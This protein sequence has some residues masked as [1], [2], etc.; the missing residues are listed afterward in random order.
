[1]TTTA[2]VVGESL[3]DVVV[4]AHGRQEHPGGSPMN[5]AIGLARL[6]GQVH[7]HT[8]FGRDARG[9]AIEIHLAESGVI[10]TAESTTDAATSSATATIGSTGAATYEFGLTSQLEPLRDLPVVDVVH[11]G[12]IGAVLEPGG[13][14]VAA[15]LAAARLSSTISY[16]PNVRPALMDP[17]ARGRVAA[18]VALSDVVK[19]S[20]EDLE[21]LNPGVDPAHT[22][23]LWARSGPA[24]V[25]LTRGAA[26]AEAYSGSTVVRVA[27][28][29]IHVVDTIGAGDS[30]MAGLLTALGDEGLL[31]AGLRPA[32]AAIDEETLRSVVAFAANCAAVTVTRAG[33]D[34]PTRS[35]LRSTQFV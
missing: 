10:A 34:P 12:S 9:R 23:A 6:G 22:A 19:A 14:V 30:F 17:A 11:T 24:I 28:P 35:E 7:L 3:T 31:G 2:L 27:A 13:Q 5:V 16:D 29:V 18:L 33:A 25:V 20:D 8:S 4:S 26:G 32:L 1:M 15:L 21:W